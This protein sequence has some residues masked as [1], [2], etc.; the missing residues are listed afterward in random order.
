MADGR[1]K[2]AQDIEN[3]LN[4]RALLYELFSFSVVPAVSGSSEPRWI[5]V[6]KKKQAGRLA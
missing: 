3:E 5:A 1:V 6:L 4:K 2:D